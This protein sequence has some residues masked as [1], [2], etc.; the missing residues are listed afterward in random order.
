VMAI[1][2][3]VGLLAAMGIANA[4]DHAKMMETK[5][6][7]GQIDNALN[8]FKQDKGYFPT[9]TGEE[10][11]QYL[12]DPEQGW[13]R[14]SL[15][16]WFEGKKKIQDGW[17][18]GF[19]YTCYTEYAFPGPDG[20]LGTADDTGR[21]VE[22]TP[23]KRDFYNAQTYQLYSMGPNMQTWLNSGANGHPRLGGTEPDDVRNWVQ[24]RF[25]KTKQEAYP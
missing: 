17:E 22:R 10:L 13:D 7:M 5:A 2:T 25:Y 15:Q 8:A 4:I 14:A 21:G 19:F 12:T 18:N 9:G 1:L 6:T 16:V 11:V 23:G 24:E 20:K 3:I